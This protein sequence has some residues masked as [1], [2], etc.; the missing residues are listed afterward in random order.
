[1]QANISRCGTGSSWEGLGVSDANVPSRPVTA[2]TY[3]PVYDVV[4]AGTGLT[5]N[6]KRP[7]YLR[8]WNGTIWTKLAAVENVYG[9]NGQDARIDALEYANSVV[10]WIGGRFDRVNPTSG[11]P[12]KINNLAKYTV[13]GNFGG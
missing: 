5:N 13:G 3:D 4:Y 1:M 8:S 11:S 12:I 7:G 6:L 2:I 10:V 9:S